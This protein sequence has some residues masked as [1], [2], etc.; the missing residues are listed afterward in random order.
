MLSLYIAFSISDSELTASQRPAGTDTQDNTPSANNT[1]VSA[2]EIPDSI[3]YM[4]VKRELGDMYA[5][6]LHSKEMSKI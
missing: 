6:R 5:A 4:H 3:I 2:Y 1:M